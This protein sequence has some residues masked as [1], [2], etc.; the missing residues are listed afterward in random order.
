M[1]I[2]TAKVPRLSFSVAT[3]FLSGAVAL[4]L[5]FGMTGQGDLPVM[6]SGNAVNQVV[7]NG[8]QRLEYLAQW[9]WEVDET[10]LATQTL[11]IPSVLGEEYGN[12]IQMQVRQGFSSLADFC[13]EEVIQYTYAVRNYPTGVEGVQVHLLCFDSHVIAGEVLSPEVGGFLHGLAYPL[14]S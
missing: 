14:D 7:K 5:L 2:I 6:S 11:Q 9:G 3:S 10:P 12:Y 8:S 1:I 13:G 4:S